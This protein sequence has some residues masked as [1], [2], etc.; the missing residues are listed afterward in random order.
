M[1][2]IIVLPCVCIHYFWLLKSNK[3]KIDLIILVIYILLSLIVFQSVVKQREI[4]IKSYPF[5]KIIHQ[6]Q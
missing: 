4:I 2:T 6:L 1:Q 5:N 3:K